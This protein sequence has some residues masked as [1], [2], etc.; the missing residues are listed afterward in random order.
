MSAKKYVHKT[1][2]YTQ[3][4]CFV[5]AS[6]FLSIDAWDNSVGKR[7]LSID[8][9]RKGNSRAC[10]SPPVASVAVFPLSATKYNLPMFTRGY[11]GFNPKKISIKNV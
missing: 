10:K 7:A 2:R 4:F 3:M 6:N 9:E 1:S 11:G 8:R 5:S